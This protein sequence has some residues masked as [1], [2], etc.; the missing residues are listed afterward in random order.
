LLFNVFSSIGPFTLAYMMSAKHIEQ[1]IYLASIYFFLHFQYNGWF[2]FAS[3]GL[4]AEKI[5]AHIISFKLQKT[6]FYLFTSAC[7]PAYFLSALW[8]PISI[9]LYII[10]VMA[11]FIQVAA[12]LVFFYEMHS[13][14]AT[15][16][17]CNKQFSKISFCFIC[18]SPFYKII[19]A[20][21]LYYSSFKHMG[22][23]FQTYRYWVFASCFFR[24]FQHLYFSQRPSSGA[25]N[26]IK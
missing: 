6:L 14:P 20:V 10:I 2:F 22:I 11:A 3:M 1:H 7:I 18:N 21:R 17:C 9:W 26:F 15:N 13:S 4:F 23:W 5:S 12:W 19:T 8:L 25:H 24:H 16:F